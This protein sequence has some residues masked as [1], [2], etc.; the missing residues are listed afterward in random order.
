MIPIAHIEKILA[1]FPLAA[2]ALYAAIVLVFL[3]T[4][5][6]TLLDLVDRHN[7]AAAAADLLA[8]L[9]GR[10]PVRSGSLAAAPSGSPFLEGATVTVAGA[11]LLQ[12]MAGAISRV[13]GNLLS[14]Q[15]D[16]KGDQ[17]K[18]GFVTATASCEI[19]AAS[20]QPLLY[21]L[22]AGMPF[23]FVD[24]LIVQAPSGTANAPGGKL[25]LLLSISGQWQGAK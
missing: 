25:R 2:V 22:E 24:Q 16:L 12:R 9:E 19:E 3:S 6:T 4:A 8:Q 13:G 1:R 11:A 10:G 18:A 7:Q 15:I 23:L 20:L 21:D 5:V 14:S 17:A